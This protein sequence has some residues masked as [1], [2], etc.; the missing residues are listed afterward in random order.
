MLTLML[1]SISMLM[2]ILTDSIQPPILTD[3]MLL[4]LLLTLILIL[5]LTD[6]IQPLILT[7]LMLLLFMLFMLMLILVLIDSIQPLILTDLMLMSVLIDSILIWTHSIGLSYFRTFHDAIYFSFSQF[8]VLHYLAVPHL[9]L[10][11]LT[12]FLTFFFLPSFFHS[13]I[14]YFILP[15]SLSVCCSWCHIYRCQCWFGN[16]Q[17]PIRRSWGKPL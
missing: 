6:S 3:L 15:Q 16:L 4:L 10:F 7:D 11:L 8:Y 2:L 13:L 9:L 1:T 17:R 14:L 12:Y 5:M